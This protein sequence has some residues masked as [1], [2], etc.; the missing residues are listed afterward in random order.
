MSRDSQITKDVGWQKDEN[1]NWY[2]EGLVYDRCC[3]TPMLKCG[4]DCF[5]INKKEQIRK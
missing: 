2:I 3:R 1:G 5:K 4:W